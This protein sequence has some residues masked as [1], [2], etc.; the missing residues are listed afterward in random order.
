MTGPAR[1]TLDEELDLFGLTDVGKVRHQNQDHFLIS[2]LHKQMKVWGSSLPDLVQLPLTSEGIAFIGM[3]ADGVGGH[4]AGA[5]ASRL[6]LES[7]AQYVTHSLHCYYTRDATQEEDFLQQLRESVLHCHASVQEQAAKHRGMEGMATTLT[8][9]LAILP[10]A[11]V[12]QVG[13]SRCYHLRDGE[14]RRITRDQTVAQD[15]VDRGALSPTRAD[16]SMW[17]HVL[18]SAIG[19][20]EARP[21][22]TR[23]D[24]EWGDVMMLCSDGLTAHVSDDEIRDHLTDLDSAETACRSLIG[25]ALERGGRDNVTVV[26]ARGRRPRRAGGRDK[27]GTVS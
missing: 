10:H 7:I 14:L 21:V 27:P 17:S 19:G 8:L 11:Y 4:A 9:L 2:S 25:R 20:G 1:R 24:L 18:T 16:D 5:E 3:V 22:I 13:D 23:L 15:L 12:V 6:A 26:I